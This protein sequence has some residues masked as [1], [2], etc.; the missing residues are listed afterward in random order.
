MTKNP[1]HSNM[2]LCKQD[3]YNLTLQF[4]YLMSQ[5]ATVV[6]IS[7]T[8]NGLRTATQVR[9]IKIH[10]LKSITGTCNLL[11]VAYNFR[12]Q[13]LNSKSEPAV[14]FQK[15]QQLPWCG[16]IKLLLNNCK[17]EG[18]EWCRVKK[19]RNLDTFETNKS[20]YLSAHYELKGILN[21]G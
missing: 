19:S 8:P 20:N 7:V 2:Q 12:P 14:Q 9:P 17:I 13:I 16:G 3:E 18:T 5:M 10:Y 4:G 1:S 21:E 6:K 11:L 15:L